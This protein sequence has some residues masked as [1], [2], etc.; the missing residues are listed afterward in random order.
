VGAILDPQTAL[1][2]EVI[3]WLADGSVR[4][5]IYTRN[6][7]LVKADGLALYEELTG[8]P[9]P[10]FAGRAPWR[11]LGPAPAAECLRPPAQR[12][13]AEPEPAVRTCEGPS[14][15][16]DNVRPYE[17]G[18]IWLCPGH[19]R[20]RYVTRRDRPEQDRPEQPDLTL[21]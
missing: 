15:D 11:T 2:G 20:Q 18:K 16:D 3:T 6:V 13:S 7:Q 9:L 14:C 5:V 8:T 4:P 19:A 12:R 1:A 10:S 21:F 17:N